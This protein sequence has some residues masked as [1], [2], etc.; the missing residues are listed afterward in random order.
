MAK[1]FGATALAGAGVAVGTLGFGM[2]SNLAGSFAQGVG[3]LGAG[4]SALRAKSFGAGRKVVA[5][6]NSANGVMSLASTALGFPMVNIGGNKAM[7]K[8]VIRP[9]GGA[10]GKVAGAGMMAS[11]VG[12][13]NGIIARLSVS[14][15]VL[16]QALSMLTN[17]ITL[18]V[19][20]VTALSA[21][22]LVLLSNLEGWKGTLG[23]LGGLFGALGTSMNLVFSQVGLGIQKLMNNVYIALDS[24]PLT[25]DLV[26]GANTAGLG[27]TG[28]VTGMTNGVKGWNENTQLGL[29]NS[30]NLEE[31]RMLKYR[32]DSGKNLTDAE[33]KR[34]NDLMWSLK[35]K[36]AGGLVSQTTTGVSQQ[37]NN[38]NLDY[39]IQKTRDYQN[40]LHVERSRMEDSYNLQNIFNPIF[41]KAKPNADIYKQ[42]MQKNQN[43]AMYAK[44]TLDNTLA[45]KANQDAVNKQTSGLKHN[46]EAVNKLTNSLVGLNLGN[47]N[48]SN[49]GRVQPS[50]PTNET[51]G[52]RT[53][54]GILTANGKFG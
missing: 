48:T 6:R 44:K 20:A 27:L 5:Q 19:L 2:V 30:R 8:S 32:Q 37:V 39:K 35:Q 46:T 40:R 33:K 29:Q 18:T 7:P 25:R 50:P 24:N 22:V 26:K 15:P 4:R 34:M 53:A 13:I 3:L 28:A 36:G 10:I 51:T 38:S 21:G 45:I 42:Q 49:N 54:R 23:A 9:A 41:G 43:E 17:P 11:G 16:G 31:V 14:I 52:Q 12:I 47:A 1:G